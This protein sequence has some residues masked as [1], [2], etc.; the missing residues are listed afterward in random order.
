[1]VSALGSAVVSGAVSRVIVQCRRVGGPPQYVG[2]TPPPQ[3]IAARY[4]PLKLCA[5]GPAGSAKPQPGS[6]AYAAW[7]TPR[8]QRSTARSTRSEE[9]TSELQSLAYLVCRLLL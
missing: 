4:Q 9:H 7:R 8:R 5:T 2:R 1:R 6:P 3:D